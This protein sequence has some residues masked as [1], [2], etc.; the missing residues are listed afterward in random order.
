TC[1]DSVIVMHRITTGMDLFRENALPLTAGVTPMKIS[2]L[3][4]IGVGEF[5][6]DPRRTLRS[7]NHRHRRL[8]VAAALTNQCH[9]HRHDESSQ[10]EKFIPAKYLCRHSPP[11]PRAARPD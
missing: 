2:E 3:V 1:N 9:V 8:G 6:L 11:L 4:S 10:Y 7:C 5:H